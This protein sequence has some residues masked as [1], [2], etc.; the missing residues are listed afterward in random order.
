MGYENKTFTPGRRKIVKHQLTVKKR[1]LE[2]GDSDSDMEITELDTTLESEPGTSTSSEKLPEAICSFNV[3]EASSTVSTQYLESDFLP[4]KDHTAYNLAFAV[5]DHFTKL[6]KIMFTDS[7]IAAGYSCGKTK[8][9]QIVKRAISVENSKVVEENCKTQPFTIMCNES[10]DR[11]NDKLFVIL[12]R[13]FD[14]ILG[15][16]V[17]R[18]LDMPI[19]NIGN[20]QNLFDALDNTFEEKQIPWKNVFGFMSD[21]CSVMKGRKKSLLFRIRQKQPNVVNMGCIC[22]LANLCCGAGV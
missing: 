19:V 21:N 16:T 14:S 17:T 20:A 22:H 18:F 6:C 2:T 8:T 10:N 15:D 11:G 9:N 5:S 3:L 1:K 12:V 7:A 4:Q 13:Y